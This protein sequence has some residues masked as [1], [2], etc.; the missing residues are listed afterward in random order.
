[1]IPDLLALVGDAADGYPG[2]PGI[3]L[4]TAARLLNRHGAIEDWPPSVLGDRRDLALLFKDL[5]TLRTDAPLFRAVD[6]LRWR[7]PTSAFAARAER[8]G[9][10]RL[11]HRCLKAP[12]A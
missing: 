12:V 8:L 3:G 4:V 11:L 9:D 1:L 6:E 5:A 2:I 7:G 10:A